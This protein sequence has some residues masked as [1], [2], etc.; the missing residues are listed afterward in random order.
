[1][2]EVYHI[3]VLKSSKKE[4]K[5]NEQIKIYFKDHWIP[6]LISTIVSS[7]IFIV[8]LINIFIAFRTDYS[9]MKETVMANTMTLQ[10]LTQNLQTGQDSQNKQIAKLVQEEDDQL[11]LLNNIQRQITQIQTFLF[12][13]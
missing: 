13:K 1:M 7:V 6:M 10:T 4:D 5:M 12:T 2:G 9:L 3:V 8:T 11:S